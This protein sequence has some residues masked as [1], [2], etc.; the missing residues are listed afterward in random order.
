MNLPFTCKGGTKRRTVIGCSPA[1]TCCSPASDDKPS[2]PGGQLLGS[3]EV[4]TIVKCMSEY[5]LGF[6]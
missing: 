2:R 4:F 5:K 1:N 6:R 3:A